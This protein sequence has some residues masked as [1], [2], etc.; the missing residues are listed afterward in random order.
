MILTK[1]SVRAVFGLNLH[2][3]FINSTIYVFDKY[4]KLFKITR[5]IDFVRFMAQAKS[6]IQF[7]TKEWKRYP[8]TEENLNFSDSTLFKLSRYWRSNKEELKE[9]R[10][11]SKKKQTTI[12]M[13]KWYNGRNGNRAGSNDGRL[14]VG[15][16]AYMVTGRGNTIKCLKLIEERTDIKCFDKNGEVDFHLFQRLDIFWLLGF[17]YWELNKMYECKNSF[18][19]TNIVNSGLPDDD[20]RKRVKIAVSLLGKL[21]NGYLFC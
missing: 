3:D 18:E 12:I 4:A 5:K 17:A 2:E 16:G 21:D 14:F 13:N 19:C 11:L 10:E 1:E 9:V 20:K 7:I 15:H 8:R 6:E